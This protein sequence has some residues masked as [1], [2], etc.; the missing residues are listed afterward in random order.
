MF[1]FIVAALGLCCCAWAF[2]SCGAW[3]PHCHGFLLQAQALGLQASV[4]AVGMGALKCRLSSCGAWAKLFHSKWHLSEPGMEPGSLALAGGFLT[5]GPRGKS[6]QDLE[7]WHGD[8]VLWLENL[9]P[10]HWDQGVLT[11]GPPG[12]SPSFLLKNIY[13]LDYYM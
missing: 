7:L 6:R 11:I 9:A 5:T 12:K 8:L 13:L 1:V 10:L 2:S 4:V 3:T